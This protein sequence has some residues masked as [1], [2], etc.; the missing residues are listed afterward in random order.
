MTHITDRGRELLDRYCTD[1]GRDCAC[2]PGS[3]D[4]EAERERNGECTGDDSCI[5][6]DH[7]DG[8]YALK[9][10]RPMPRNPKPIRTAPCT[11]CGATNTIC[12]HTRIGR[13]SNS[14]VVLPTETVIIRRWLPGDRPVIV[15]RTHRVGL[16]RPAR[17]LTYAYTLDA[18]AKMRA[19]LAEQT[20]V[21]Q[22]H[23]PSELCWNCDQFIN[24]YALHRCEGKPS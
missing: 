14:A 2:E 10:Q 4:L 15:H 16:R 17:N 22:Q 23:I 1:C 11:V 18:L 24:P 9:W 6:A 7:Y 13:V 5:A 3:S 20:R 21:P 12:P 8:C 19:E